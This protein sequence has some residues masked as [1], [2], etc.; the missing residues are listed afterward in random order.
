M[1]KPHS[2]TLFM[3]FLGDAGQKKR[4][5][6]GGSWYHTTAPQRSPPI[7]APQPFGNGLNPILHPHQV[8]LQK[9]AYPLL[10]QGPPWFSRYSGCVY[11]ILLDIRTPNLAIWRT[12]KCAIQIQ[13]SRHICLSHLFPPLFKCHTV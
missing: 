6:V 7:S 2:Q 5:V 13:N 10:A 4:E 12:L 11:N 1:G 3:F 9:F 8:S